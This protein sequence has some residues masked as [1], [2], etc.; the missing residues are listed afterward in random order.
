MISSIT[1]L[2]A[3]DPQNDQKSIVFFPSL[4]FSDELAAFDFALLEPQ[5]PNKNNAVLANT[6]VTNNFFI[7]S[8]R[9]LI[10]RLSFVIC[11]R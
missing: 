4:V 1:S 9:F 2:R 10:K 6:P 11:N 8:L 7:L 5:P 3:P